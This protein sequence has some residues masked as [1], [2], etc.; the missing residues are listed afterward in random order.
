M[1]KISTLKSILLWNWKELIYIMLYMNPQTGSQVQT[2]LFTRNSTFMYS[3]IH[4]ALK[5]K[6][7]KMEAKNI[8]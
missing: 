8:A 7:A 1:T 3:F 2:F 5:E 4:L 6:Q